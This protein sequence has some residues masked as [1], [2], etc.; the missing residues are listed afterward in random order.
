M[1]KSFKVI[2][3]WGV[4]LFLGGIQAWA[5]LDVE[6]HFIDPQYA[7]KKLFMDFKD[8]ALVDILKIFSK[9][10]NSNF[11]AAPDVA[12]KKIT[13]YLNGVAFSEALK[14][15]LDA[16]DL[17]Y[18]MQGDSNIFIVKTKPKGDESKITKVYQLKY[19]TVSTSKLNSTISVSGGSGGASSSSKG[20]LEDAVK[21]ALSK[22][23]KLI[24]DSRTNSLIISDIPEQFV[25]IENTIAKLD[26]PIPQVLIEVEMIE[27]DKGTA[28]QL[29]IQYGSSG[30]SFQ[31]LAFTGGT[32]S[33][34]WPFGPGS[35][36]S[37][38]SGSSSSSSSSS[39]STSGNGGFNASGMT[40]TVNFF[41]SQ[42]SSR[43]LARPRILTL[44]NETAQIQISTDQALSVEQTSASTTSSGSTIT[45]NTVERHQT[46]VI[47][48][49]TPQAN[50]LTREI[51]M[52]L[53]PQII[54]VAQS[55]LGASIWDDT[56][57]SSDSILRLKDG[58]CMVIG[59]LLNTSTSNNTV[60][61][62]FLGDLPLIGSAFRYSSKSKSNRELLIFLTPHIIDDNSHD[63]LKAD[64]SPVQLE[65]SAT[66][67]KD[68]TQRLEDVD[69]TLNI[70]ELKRN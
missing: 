35:N 66:V 43:T 4:F 57:R 31:P 17:V 33:T 45:G 23:G 53:S 58:Q 16:N 56:K 13:L 21:E 22:D 63:V 49:V 62:P 14:E 28:D 9:Q 25:G 37:S 68:E 34:N 47:L 41:A 2:C 46:G 36:T 59:G 61:L 60:K 3:V 65:S 10:S 30:L 48:K 67:I 51:T 26:V 11:V 44:N 7:T 69:Q 39:G 8:A 50:L 24:E 19:A 40:A 29:G 52:A 64:D 70:Y 55:N 27:V 38:S 5:G 6:E 12:D 1:F 18:E 15:I 42:S 32:K 20:G 54:D